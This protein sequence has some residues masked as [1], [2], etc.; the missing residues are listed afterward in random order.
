MGWL[1]QTTPSENKSYLHF[2]PGG[3]GNMIWFEAV[4]EPGRLVLVV[5]TGSISNWT[6]SCFLYISWW[7][8]PYHAGNNTSRE[9]CYL[10]TG[11]WGNPTQT[12]GSVMY[13]CTFS[14]SKCGSISKYCFPQD[15]SSFVCLSIYLINFRSGFLNLNMVGL[16]GQRILQCRGGWPV[17]CRMFSNILGS[18]STP[19]PT[20]DCDKPNC[21]QHYQYP[22]GGKHHR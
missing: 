12:T 22:S 3:D 16:L 13:C 4:A 21:F 11:G 14:S 10:W 15:F 1:I 7:T 20:P 18:C 8:S 5:L 17:H 2:D 9:K 19:T 6:K